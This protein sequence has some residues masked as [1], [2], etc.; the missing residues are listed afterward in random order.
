M[1]EFLKTIG[2]RIRDKRYFTFYHADPEFE[3]HLAF[4]NFNRTW[5]GVLSVMASTCLFFTLRLN[6][7]RQGH[8]LVGYDALIRLNVIVFFAAAI[9]WGLMKKFRP[10]SP[11]DIT[12]IHALLVYSA[13]FMFIFVMSVAAGFEYLGTGALTRFFF[14]IVCLCIIFV[15]NWFVLMFYFAISMMVMVLTVYA[16]KG[17]VMILG[18]EHMHIPILLLVFWF[19]SR[20]CYMGA[21]KDFQIR[22]K[23]E[24]AN[25]DLKKENAGR[26]KALDDLKKSEGYLK[27]L[28]E[29]A[30]D[31][32]V[33][34]DYDRKMVTQ[35]N[36]CAEELFGYKNCE[37][38]GKT[39]RDIKV[40]GEDDC[41]LID[42]IIEET[43]EYT[44]AGPYEFS[45]D[46]RDKR[47]VV[48]ESRSSLTTMDGRTMILATIRDI[49]WRKHAEDKLLQSNID[50]EERV[51][52]RSQWLEEVNSRLRKEISDHKH[53]ENVL[54]KTEEQS[55]V[56]IEKM[57]DGFVVFNQSMQ[58]TYANER[59]CAMLGY[60]SADILGKSFY[61]FVQEDRIGEFKDHLAAKGNP[62][63]QACETVLK[64]SGGG[65]LHAYFSPQ[66]LYGE[67]GR[68]E[69][70][71]SV[72]TDI[73]PIKIMEAALRESEEMTRA[74]LDASR[75]S[76][77][78]LTPDGTILM[79]N[80]MLASNLKSYPEKLKGLN[81]FTFLEPDM[82][83]V[84]QNHLMELGA[85]KEPSI[86]ED[87]YGGRH[88]LLHIYPIQDK[89]PS[90]ERV[91]VFARDISDLKKAEKH[92]RSLSQEL[93]KVQENERQRISRDLHDNVAQELASLKI[94]CETLFDG[95]QAIPA[96]V[97]GKMGSF[98][99]ILQHTIM[100]VR[101]MAYDL[102]PP[103]LDQ[104]GLVSTLGNYCD[105]YAG[106]NNIDV[107]F[108][109][110]GVSR[111]TL[112]ADSEINLYRIIQEA[113]H[114]VVKHARASQVTI[115]LTASF[116][117]IILRIEDDGQGFDLS[118]RTT[119][120]SMEKH[121]GL[122]SMEERA[123]LLSGN[124]SIRSHK[125][126]G[127]KIAVEI[128]I[129]GNTI[130]NDDK[131]DVLYG[132]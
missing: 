44:F 115:R 87:I 113:L 126:K 106:R 110:A 123:R 112:T 65:P 109:S 3:K 76:V 2:A 14:A 67:T 40:L 84:R 29:K 72:I 96:E 38:A 75:D 15:F 35:I 102:R 39:Y 129:Q 51:R 8:V 120:A 82:T 93:I 50:L 45:V 114:N 100:S 128:P 57:N 130:D 73:T 9:F 61:S 25:A 121:M 28:F 124:F 19:I 104:L 11:N 122:R 26:I 69:G 34:Y 66:A 62:A 36:A 41:L 55:R 107:D 68:V 108:F 89:G 16:V 71:F 18:I 111:Y 80:E 63:R 24:H 81:I 4:F 92:I 117:T 59:F 27:T 12:R 85:K 64:K 101:D 49:T 48:V 1:F 118:S 119:S 43:L 47:N 33:L 21:V 56:L 60:P 127:T 99:T 88:F 79:A 78:M 116:P 5:I 46:L 58:V 86:V 94:I 52:E 132:S 6:L 105:D 31:A 37:V 74:L 83:S 13:A 22:K 54:R 70:R 7:Y 95:N 17:E 20:A 53:T 97:K 42:G 103:G 131:G 90:I 91:A 32:Y 98:S 77:A 125:G 10:P 23:L 30:P